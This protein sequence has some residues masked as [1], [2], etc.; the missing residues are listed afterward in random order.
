[1][2]TWTIVVAAG[3]STRFGRPKPYELLAGRRVLDWSLAAA[4][5]A[6]D[7]VVLVV[8][9]AAAGRAEPGADAV[10]VG[11][12][13]RAGSVRCGLAAVPADA[14]VVIVHDAARPL[15]GPALFRAAVDA[16]RAGAAGAVCAVPLADTLKRVEGT[17]VAATVDRA[18]LWAVQTPQAF[19]ADALRAAH[20][21]GGEATDDAGLVEALG[22]RVVVVP[23]DPANLKLTGPADLVIAEALAG[24]P[25]VRVGQGYDVHALSD[26]PARPLVLGGVTFEGAPGLAGHSDADVVAHAVADALLGAAGLGDLGLHFPDTDP[27]WSGADSLV[28]LAEVVRRLAGAGWR[29]ANADCTVVLERPRLAPHRAV[30]E[31]RLGAVLDAPVSVKAATPEG[32]GALGRGEGIACSAVALVCRR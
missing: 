30:M 14:D 27:A 22:E 10:V 31:A 26:D 32:L 6:G 5:G 17:V 19:R 8:P 15:A 16:V 11:A 18:G 2:P 23:G 7:G 1:M 29:P 12:A 3:D 4:R 21:G 28:L 24:A 13:S 9:E 25:P 20:A